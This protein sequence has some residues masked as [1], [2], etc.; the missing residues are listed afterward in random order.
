MQVATIARL[1]NLDVG[2]MDLGI[3]PHKDNR[4]IIFSRHKYVTRGSD[5][6]VVEDVIS[7]GK[8]ASDRS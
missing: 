7:L 4:R 3:V 6:G 8:S 1:L 2:E 5:F